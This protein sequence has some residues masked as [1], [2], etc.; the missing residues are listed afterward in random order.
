M[1]NISRMIAKTRHAQIVC[2]NAPGWIAH[3]MTSMTE[4]D[5]FT[6]RAPHNKLTLTIFFSSIRPAAVLLS[7]T[8]LPP[9]PCSAAAP[10]C[11]P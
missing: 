3:C 9:P 2:G 6:S 10:S 8:R 11:A 1:A 5:T 7:E 4:T